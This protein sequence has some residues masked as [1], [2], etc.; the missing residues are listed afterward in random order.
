VTDGPARSLSVATV[1]V[2]PEAA[3]G[4]TAKRPFWARGQCQE[5]TF[6]GL[7][8]SGQRTPTVTHGE[9]SAG[10]RMAAKPLLITC[11]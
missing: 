3:V 1:S 10:L 5:Q 7:S 2:R 4:Q 8:R 6:P 11:V 9:E